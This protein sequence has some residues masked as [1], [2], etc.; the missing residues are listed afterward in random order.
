MPSFDRQLCTAMQAGNCPGKS[1]YVRNKFP[2]GTTSSSSGHTTQD[3]AE[4]Y[5]ETRCSVNSTTGNCYPNP[6]V[7]P[8][9]TADKYVASDNNPCE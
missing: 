7:L 3:E 1:Q 8:W 4:C 6:N 2:E 9:A 5:Q